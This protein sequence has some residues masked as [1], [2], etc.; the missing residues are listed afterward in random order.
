MHSHFLQIID[1]NFSFDQI[2]H[3]F[4]K[5]FWI[6]YNKI[7]KF[8][9]GLRFW[10]SQ[11]ATSKES[12]I[13]SFCDHSHVTHTRADTKQH[14]KRFDSKITEIWSWVYSDFILLDLLNG[15][16]CSWT[17]RACPFVFEKLPA[18]ISNFNQQATILLYLWIERK[19]W[20]INYK[21]IF[22]L[23][24][25]HLIYRIFTSISH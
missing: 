6:D 2:F 9:D 4:W 11:T 3:L 22:F 25:I 20:I 15:K 24:C 21:I 17:C 12:I 7:E 8:G 13:A 5:P 1:E 19:F 18:H 23:K 10:S 14:N 16:F